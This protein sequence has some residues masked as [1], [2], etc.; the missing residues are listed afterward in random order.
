MISLYYNYIPHVVFPSI[1]FIVFIFIVL[2][3]ISTIA[4]VSVQYSVMQ[5]IYLVPFTEDLN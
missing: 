5:N 1:E 3:T 4:G 2:K